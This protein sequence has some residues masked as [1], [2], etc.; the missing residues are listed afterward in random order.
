MVH[1]NIHTAWILSTYKAGPRKILIL[2][3]K[4]TKSAFYLFLRKTNVRYIYL[5]V[6]IIR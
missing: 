3:Q 6:I 2:I 5:Y 4:N 1:L